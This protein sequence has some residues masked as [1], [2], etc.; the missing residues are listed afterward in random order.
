MCAG[1]PYP[2]GFLKRAGSSREASRPD[3]L[4]TI[5]AANARKTLSAIAC[6]FSR[7]RFRHDHVLATHVHFDGAAVS[8][9]FY[10]ECCNG[11]APVWPRAFDAIDDCRC[12]GLVVEHGALP[13]RIVAEDKKC[14]ARSYVIRCNAAAY[15]VRRRC[16]THIWQADAD[17]HLV[18]TG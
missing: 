9:L 12:S 4:P 18:Q 13:E 2:S 14:S 15:Q 5:Q 6:S 3:H 8:R 17:F 7:L 16:F 10:V 11:A 1:L